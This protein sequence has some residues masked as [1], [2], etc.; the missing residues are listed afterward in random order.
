VTEKYPHTTIC[1]FNMHRFGADCCCHNK[2]IAELE[3]KLHEQGVRQSAI[4]LQDCE[5][6]D[7]AERELAEAQ[8]TVAELRALLLERIDTTIRRGGE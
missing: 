2:R 3:K 8:D 7:K 5:R 1:V 4:N 6:A